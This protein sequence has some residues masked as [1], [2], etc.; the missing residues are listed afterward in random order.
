MGLA[1]WASK[2]HP[3]WLSWTPILEGSKPLV[4]T[5]RAVSSENDQREARWL[6]GALELKGIGS[7]RTRV[8]E[9]RGLSESAAPVPNEMPGPDSNEF[10]FEL[11]EPVAD[12]IEAGGGRLRGWKRE[13]N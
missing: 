2:N 9:L 1:D 3:L 5:T 4:D 11:R 6:G 10:L 12:S 7:T 8:K 13:V